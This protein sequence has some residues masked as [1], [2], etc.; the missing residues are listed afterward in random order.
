M[1]LQKVMASLVEQYMKVYQERQTVMRKIRDLSCVR[2]RY[3]RTTLAD[4]YKAAQITC[5]SGIHFF[6]TRKEAVNY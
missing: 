5:A 4:W 1:E 6:T 3:G 2:A